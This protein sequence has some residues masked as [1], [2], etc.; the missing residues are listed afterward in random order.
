M[1]HIRSAK[2]EAFNL[3]IYKNNRHYVWR[4]DIDKCRRHNDVKWYT[5]PNCILTKIC[6]LFQEWYLRMIWYT[7]VLGNRSGKTPLQ[8]ATVSNDTDKALKNLFV[9]L[10]R[11][12]SY[13][14]PT[15]IKQTSF[16]PLRRWPRPNSNNSI[17]APG[18]HPQKIF[19]NIDHRLVK[20]I[21]AAL[22]IT[23]RQ[24]THHL[25]PTLRRHCFPFFLLQYC[26]QV[27]KTC[28]ECKQADHNTRHA[29][30]DSGRWC[31]CRS[32]GG[33]RCIQSHG[34]LH[35]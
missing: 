19:S 15:R 22:S 33:S 34:A 5:N 17:L 8:H 21:D 14:T 6:K 12:G 26:L 30:G 29:S 13:R 9:F 18:A 1:H 32:R 27:S 24:Y 3:R 16:V 7:L 31:T 28:G 10:D 2:A 20:N 11:Q 25:L 4:N 23:Y 35:A